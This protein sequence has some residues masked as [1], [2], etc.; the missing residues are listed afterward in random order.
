MVVKYLEGTKIEE[1]FSRVL[2]GIITNELS[3]IKKVAV[4]ISG[5]SDS[6]ALFLLLKKFLSRNVKIVGLTIDHNLRSQSEKEA[7]QV[8]KT[9]KSFDIEHHT[10]RWEHKTINSNV[11][12]K[13]REA[14]YELLIKFCQKNDINH[15]FV[16]HHF[17][18]QA[19]TVLMNI[20]RGTGIDGLVGMRSTREDREV[21][22]LRPLLS[23]TKKMI[24]DYLSVKKVSYISDPSN[25]NENFTRVQVRKLLSSKVVPQ[26]LTQ[27]LN[28]LSSNAKRVKQ[29][30]ENTTRETFV[31]ICRWGNYGEITAVFKDLQQLDEEILGRVINLI[32]KKLHNKFLYPVRLNSLLKIIT[33]IKSHEMV[34]MTLAQCKIL[35]AGDMIYFFKENKYIETEKELCV[36]DNIWDGRLEIK[37]KREGYK[38]KVMNKNIWGQIKPRNYLKKI[39]LSLLMSTPTILDKNNYCV[40]HMLMKQKANK[41]SYDICIKFC[42]YN[43][44]YY[45]CFDDK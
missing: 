7:S 14:R 42:Q 9:I 16:G 1:E 4:A 17:D 24:E 32:F 29:F 3:V 5:G 34:S 15:L 26:D 20:F 27:R 31:S 10:L 40:Y 45:H 2:S 44:Y 25:Y 8:S 36:G 33:L 30:L 21:K 38:V 43:M 28:L 23:L 13:A 35:C 37:I 39:P 6:M 19:E 12:N 22:I 18:D 41:Y 11:Q